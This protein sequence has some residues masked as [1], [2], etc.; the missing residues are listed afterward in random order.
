MD[1]FSI[2]KY[3]EMAKRRVYWI[4]IPFLVVSL[5]GLYYI[6]TTPK[7]YETKTLILVQ[8][9]KVP[10][11]Y[12]KSTV[13]TSVQDRLRTITEQVTSRTNLEN[14]IQEYQLFSQPSEKNLLME[15]KVALVKSLIKIKIETGASERSSDGTFSI[16]F[17]GSDP[18]KITEAT[19]SLASNFISENLKIR[20]SQA[21]GTSDFLSDELESVRKK[22][23]EKEDQ[24]KEYKE[25]YMGGLPEQLDTNLKIIDRL[26]TQLDQLNNKLKTAEDKGI[27][28]QQAIASDGQISTG[29]SDR[30]S[31]SQSGG[32]DKLSALKNELLSLQTRYTDSYPDIIQLKN[33]I[34]ALE[35]TQSNSKDSTTGEASGGKTE[36]RA[37]PAQ[38]SVNKKLS[39]QL[40]DN[41]KEILRLKSA[42]EETESQIN[43]YQT[44]VKQTPDRAQE[45]LSLNRD[46][47]NL[48]SLYSTMLN[49]EL[50]SE[51]SL[52]LEKKQQ[53]EQFKIIDPAKV[54]IKPIN[55]DV[56]KLSLMVLAMGL[57]MG[58]GLAYVIEMMD[59]TFRGSEEIEK[60]FTIPVLIV[61][62]MIYTQAEIIR[63]KRK[64]VFVA[65][66]ICIG[67][68]LGAVGVVFAAKG[69]NI[70]VDY[71][72][73]IL[74]K[75]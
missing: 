25:K 63:N 16:S 10:E 75:I 61:M 46:Y 71:L 18:N 2:K 66:S 7:V 43:G 8:A 42:I 19:N 60:E 32:E 58:C 55:P 35:E 22:L 29:S 73:S 59:T 53:G 6:L 23:K 36:Q 9:Q 67:F 14:I 30:F 38:S 51:I 48:N 41:N 64:K 12:V 72:K 37:L 26:Q 13:T 56:Q 1:S 62:P 47:N 70:T 33:K 24:L 21:F 49:R 11:N 68:I 31:P 50:E 3:L 4:V 34:T 40:D 44:K 28:L 15:E 45:M 54:P 20:E 69:V 39:S 65:A 74:V 5:G 52:N 27:A 17:Q 57:G